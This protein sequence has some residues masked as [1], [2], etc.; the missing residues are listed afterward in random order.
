MLIAF[1]DTPVTSIDDLQRCMTEECIG[2]RG[3]I[4]LLRGAERLERHLIP[5]DSSRYNR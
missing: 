3:T 4:T 2:V 5:A 1:G